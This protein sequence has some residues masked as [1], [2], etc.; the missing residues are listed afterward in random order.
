[1][2]QNL[3]ALYQIAHSDGYQWW[4]CH[5]LFA[6][7]CCQ[8]Y[9]QERVFISHA[10]PQKGFALHV[11]SRLRDAGVSAFVDERDLQ[12]GAD[13]TAFA[14]MEAACRQA[15]LVVFVVTRDFLQRPATLQELRWAL[16]QRQQP[17]RQAAAGSAGSSPAAVLPHML[18]V[19]YPTP[20][21][22]SWRVP[23]LQQLLSQMQLPP[24]AA[25]AA[26]EDLNKATNDATVDVGD[27][28]SGSLEGLL[29][30]Y[31]PA[32]GA[33]GSAPAAV[34]A[35]QAATDLAKLAEATVIRDDSVAR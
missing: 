7:Y 8:V 29:Q 14:V 35:Q 15:Q 16:D 2:T 24:G 9:S 34:T 6:L 23:E 31:H 25:R 27:L 21:S 33:A 13:H 22:P 5:T 3:L 17:Q 1:M 28:R 26:A 19:L 30:H 10:G 20:V 18:A 32:V 12:P 11:R 4:T